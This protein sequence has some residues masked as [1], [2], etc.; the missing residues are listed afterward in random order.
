M[1]EANFS[2]S[3]LQQAV[4]TAYTLKIHQLTGNVVFAHVP[5]LFDEFDLG[6]DSAFFLDW[7]PHSP[8]HSHEGCN[9]FIQYKLSGQLTSAGAKEWKHWNSEYFRF[10]I[11]HFTRDKNGLFV[12]DF[13]QWDRL[14]ELA[15]LNYP[16]YYATNSVLRKD[17]LESAMKAGN[18]LESVPLLDVRTVTQLHKHVTFTP[19]SNGFIMH[20]EVEEVNKYSFEKLLS[21]RSQLQMQSIGE[22]NRRMLVDFEKIGKKNESWSVDL[23]RIVD[24]Q[25]SGLPR[26]LGYLFVRSMLRSFARKH[27]GSDMLWLPKPNNLSELRGRLPSP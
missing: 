22:T 19:L 24:A 3:Q 7:L 17:E 18:L 2:E 20:S 15:D 21:L 12:D 5:S 23:A 27:T 9:I 13:H 1:R 14:K 25:S 16:T 26:E 11:P 8:L 10:K 4:N 6:F